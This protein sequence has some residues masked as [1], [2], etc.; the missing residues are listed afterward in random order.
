MRNSRTNETPAID[1]QK[2]IKLRKI[3]QILRVW[4]LERVS[5]LLESLIDGPKKH[6][7]E[8]SNLDKLVEIIRDLDEALIVSLLNQ[9]RLMEQRRQKQTTQSMFPRIAVTT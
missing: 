9:F 6:R 4:P 2:E 1:Y 8:Q 5:F 7:Q 3:S